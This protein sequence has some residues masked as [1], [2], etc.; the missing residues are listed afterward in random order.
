MEEAAGEAAAQKD[1]S[2]AVGVF[3]SVAVECNDIVNDDVEDEG[4]GGFHV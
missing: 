3:A 1:P 2:F 4:N